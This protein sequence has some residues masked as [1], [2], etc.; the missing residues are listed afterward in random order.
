[1][2]ENRWQPPSPLI[3]RGSSEGDSPA[4]LAPS[5]TNRFD[6][7]ALC[8]LALV[9]NC[10]Q[11]LICKPNLCQF[12][13]EKLQVWA[14]RHTKRRCLKMFAELIIH[15]PSERE[16]G[17]FQTKCSH[18]KFHHHHSEIKRAFPRHRSPGLNSH[19]IPYWI[20]KIPDFCF[21]NATLQPCCPLL[22]SKC[23]CW[24]LR[25]RYCKRSPF[26]CRKVSLITN[27]K[28]FC[29]STCF[30]FSKPQNLVFK[31]YQAA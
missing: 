10:S 19:G 26:Y 8:S 17:V 2:K 13:C 18:L 7:N 23:H 5:L 31:I 25:K 29:I 16:P 20:Q 6:G 22:P 24:K 21:P 4:H 12:N 27:Y 1:M 30:A 14:Q 28:P 9:S 15:R 3:R 11:S